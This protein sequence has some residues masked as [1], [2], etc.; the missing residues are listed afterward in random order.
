MSQKVNM[1]HSILIQHGNNL[2]AIDL[3][4]VNHKVQSLCNSNTLCAGVA[5]VSINTIW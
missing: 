5:R 1:H 4:P 2:T 3:Q